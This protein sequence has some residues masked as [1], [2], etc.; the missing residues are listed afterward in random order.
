MNIN[1]FTMTEIIKRNIY[2]KG[3]WD[4]EREVFE[5]QDPDNCAV[6]HIADDIIWEMRNMF[7]DGKN[8]I[9]V[10]SDEYEYDGRDIRDDVDCIKI[11][12]AYY[13][14][15]YKVYPGEILFVKD[16]TDMSIN[17]YRCTKI[18]EDYVYLKED[19]E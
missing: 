17:K 9:S 10:F 11:K 13:N 14:I 7:S 4:E 8:M 6:D 19:I 12:I 16:L 1:K 3:S 15:D 18:D 5:I 2:Q